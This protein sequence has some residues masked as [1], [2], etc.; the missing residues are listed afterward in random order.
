MIQQTPFIVCARCTTFNHSKYIV[1]AMNGFTMQET[2]FPFVCTIIDDASTDGEQEVIKKYLK[3]YFNLD[4]KSV[5]RNEETNDYVLTFARHKTNKNCYFAVLYLKYNHYNIKKNK[6]FYIAEWLDTAKYTA[7]C[8]GDDYWTDPN[9][10]Q[11]QVDFL[12]SHPNYGMVYTNYKMYFQDNGQTT[13]SNCL[14]TSFEDEITRNRVATLTTLVR[15]TLLNQYKQEIGNTPYERGWMM[16]D[17]PTWI[18]IMANSKAKLIPD[19]TSVYRVLKNSASHHS[20]YEKNKDFLLSTYD[21]CF[22][23]ANKYNVS[24][25]IRKTIANNEI[26]DLLKLANKHNKNLHFPLIKFMV[27]NEIFDIKKFFSVKLRSSVW[28]RKIYK[29]IKAV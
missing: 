4:D 17:Y 28:G 6:L 29:H 27:K 14:Q 19:I 2:T 22:Y 11:K 21:I 26:N 24:T 3:E 8:E 5:V 18:F 10:L 12:E 16:G 25:E 20:S 23:F 1:D 9:K 7:L 15:S 13:I